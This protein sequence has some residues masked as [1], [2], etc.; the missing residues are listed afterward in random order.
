MSEEHHSAD[1][2]DYVLS[3]V[4]DES[5]QFL[6]IHADLR[7]IDLLIDEL[8]SLRGQLLENDCPH[9]HL[10]AD[11]CGGDELTSTKLKDQPGEAKIVSHVKIYGWNEEWARRHGLK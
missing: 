11:E 2:S 5:G 3:F 6:S 1:S 8:Q 4:T 10:V 7:G 9:T